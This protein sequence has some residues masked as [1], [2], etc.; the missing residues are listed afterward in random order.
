MP[1]QK[2]QKTDAPS[3]FAVEAL[4][5]LR[6]SGLLQ[7]V[8]TLAEASPE[9]LGAMSDATKRRAPDDLPAPSD[10][11]SDSH[12]ADWDAVSLPAASQAPV[13]PTGYKGGKTTTGLPVGMPSVEEWGRTLNELPKYAAQ[14]YS[15]FEMWNLA[16][17]DKAMANY[18]EWCSTYAGPS[19]KAKDLGAYVRMMRQAQPVHSYFPGSSEVRRLK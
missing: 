14:E 15:Y 3:Q 17:T 13:V 8:M 18:L 9:V 5:A 4:D 11:E 1:S 7:E 6:K 16:K 19:A 12:I 10:V 2:Q